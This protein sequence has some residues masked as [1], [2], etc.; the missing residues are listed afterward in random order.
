MSEQ[1]DA[2]RA[3]SPRS[4][5]L[6]LAQLCLEKR[7]WEELLAMGEAAKMEETNGGDLAAR[8]ERW[9]AVE[10]CVNAYSG[11]AHAFGALDFFS[12]EHEMWCDLVNDQ[13]A[14][15]MGDGILTRSQQRRFEAQYDRLLGGHRAAEGWLRLMVSRVSGRMEM[16]AN[17]LESASGA[18]G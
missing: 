5:L 9:M 10:Q 15:G 11:L 13:I 6:A 4:R 3:M 17:C 1:M 7:D 14:Q 8:I 12:E 18:T 16:L 2:L